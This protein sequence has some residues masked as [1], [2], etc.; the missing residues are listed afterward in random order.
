M[1]IRLA[2]AQCACCGPVAANTPLPSRGPKDAAQP[3]E[4]RAANGQQ[5]N[6]ANETANPNNRR[7]ARSNGKNVTAPSIESPAKVNRMGKTPGVQAP[8][9]SV[10]KVTEAHAERQRSKEKTKVTMRVV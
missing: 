1:R 9:G 8:L 10:S 7:T 2:R 3:E 6:A 5:R 4:D